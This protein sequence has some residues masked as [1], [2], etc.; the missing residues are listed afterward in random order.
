VQRLIFLGVITLEKVSFYPAG[1][2]AILI[3]FEQEISPEINGRITALVRLIKAQQIEGIV[4][5][6]PSFC[7][8]LV[9][10]DS[11][12]IS[13]KQINRRLSKLVQLDV[14]TEGQSSRV[15]EIPTCYGGDYGPDINYIAEK[16]GL[17]IQDVIN[18][19]SSKEYLIYMLGFMPGFSYLGGLDE[20]IHTPRLETPRVKI[21]GG[22]VGIAGGQTGIYPLDS[23]GGWQL[24]GLTPV[25]TY[26]PGRKVP[27]LYNAGDYI[28]F[29]P[30]S[31]AEFLS[32]KAQVEDGTFECKTTEI[33]KGA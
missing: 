1:D 25:K 11:R 32:V 21:R 33:G 15:F 16:A 12:V 14:K 4:D 23:P 2:S 30:I 27:I 5:M 26:D 7:A 17:S 18:I 31:E 29:V 9:N 22:S 20:R 10:Y 3:A 13:Y 24:L 19:H 28:R 6:I 8:L